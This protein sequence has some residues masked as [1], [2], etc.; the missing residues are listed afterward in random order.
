M[1][2]AQPALACRVAQRPDVGE[3]G[4]TLVEFMIAA[5]IM[6]I[7]LGGT[8]MLATQIQ[9]A[10]GTQL[11]DVAVEQEARYALDWIARDLRSA[12]SDPYTIIPNNQEV[13]IDPN[14][15]AD[16]DDSIRVQADVNPPDG[17]IADERENIT[18]A[19]DSVN[20]VITRRDHAVDVAGVAM[21][22]A[23]FTD[24]RFTHLNAARV[25]TAVP[26]LVAY[27]QVQVTAQSRARNPFTG[28]FTS[29]TLAT[30]VR[31]RTR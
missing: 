21:T 4:F 8:V 3:G 15:G 23:I 19:I 5:A 17:D 13:W 28:T 16:P 25:A 22:E 12:A 9:Q 10:Y 2:T 11:D 14:A 27:V 30:E 18:I 29:S 1:R 6:T 31:L 7:V 20:R 24:L 26:E